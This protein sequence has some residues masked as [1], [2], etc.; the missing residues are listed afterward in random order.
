MHATLCLLLYQCCSCLGN[1]CICL[2][3]ECSCLGNDCKQDILL[4]CPAETILWF[5]TIA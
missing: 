2:G 1:D 5:L 4:S 3:N